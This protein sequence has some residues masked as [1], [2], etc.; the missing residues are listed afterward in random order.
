MAR[1]PRTQ[2]RK[3]SSPEMVSLCLFFSLGAPGEPDGPRLKL[4]IRPTPYSATANQ[5]GSTL[6]PSAVRASSV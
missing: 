1:K 5:P 6:S 3:N 4:R 2:G